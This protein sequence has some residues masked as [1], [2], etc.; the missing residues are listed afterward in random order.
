M[1]FSPKNFTEFYFSFFT[2]HHFKRILTVLFIQQ[3]FVEHP[4]NAKHMI[5]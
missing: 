2:P 1:I 3:T 4:P 5:V